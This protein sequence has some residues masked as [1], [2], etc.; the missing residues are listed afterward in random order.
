MHNVLTQNTL[1][2]TVSETMNESSGYTV[3]KRKKL[4]MMQYNSLTS[5][6]S[7]IYKFWLKFGP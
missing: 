3:I 2:F 4:Q 5:L 7:N 6:L 1:P